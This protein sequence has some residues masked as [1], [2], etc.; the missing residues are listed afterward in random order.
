MFFIP[1]SRR[2]FKLLTFLLVA[3]VA[4]GLAG[5]GGSSSKSTT[6]LN[7]TSSSSKVAS[8]SSVTLQALISSGKPVTG[9]VI[10]SDGTTPI[11]S[12][13]AITNGVAT[14]STSALTVGTHAITAT[15]SGDDNNQ[16][17]STLDTL[18]QTITGQFTLTVNAV[19]GTITHA[20][21]VPATLQ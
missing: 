19:S 6:A 14:L 13:A 2:N 3:G 1:K 20:I 16:P 15:Y 11:G 7:V 8:G 21:P 12:P 17:A 9:F 18:E 10:F 4:S 5:C